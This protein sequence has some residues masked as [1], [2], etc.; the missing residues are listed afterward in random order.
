MRQKL[1]IISGSPWIGKSTIG[2]R[3]FEM[4]ENS[5]Y[6]DGDWAWCVN[7]F[8]V[9]DPRLRNGDKSMSFILS[10]YLQ[11][12][13]DY[14]FFASVIATDKKIRDSIIKNIVYD[15]YEIK[16][17]TLT[18]SRETL[19]KRHK[20]RND[21]TTINYYFLDLPPHQGDIVI[22]TDN[23]TLEQLCNEIYQYIVAK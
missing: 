8:S 11:S 3:V 19:A 14:V 17:F 15:D 6:L 13:F 1:I 5:A 22:N 16:S 12:K 4:L 20:M 18:C 10:T 23:K 21:D 2:K 9:R 7:P